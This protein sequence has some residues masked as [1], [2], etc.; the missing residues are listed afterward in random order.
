MIKQTLFYIAKSQSSDKRPNLNATK[1]FIRHRGCRMNVFW[2]LNS[3]LVSTRCNAVVKADK[4]DISS[5]R[6]Q[7]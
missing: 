6:P 1:T 2:I 5:M 4:A 7:M 3:D